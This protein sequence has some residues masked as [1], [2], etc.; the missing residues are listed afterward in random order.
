M[1]EDSDGTETNGPVI[2]VPSS[3]GKRRLRRFDHAQ[4]TKN[5][6]LVRFKRYLFRQDANGLEAAM[7]A[8]DRLNCWSDALRQLRLNRPAEKHGQILVSFWIQ[9]G[10]SS[11]PMGLRDDLPDLIDTMRRFLKPYQGPP[12][13]LYRGELEAR[14][15]NGIFGIAWTTNL[16]TAEMFA[17]RRVPLQEGPGIV[18]KIEATADVIVADLKRHSAHATNI[19]EEE[20]L[21][22]PRLI[23]NMISVV[24]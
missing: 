8:L 19:G 12:V 5:E 20:Y 21:V 3:T 16:T 23:R 13:T 14:Y 1:L 17:R 4:W 24:D 15:T 22:D 2:E 7:R 11:I 9:H 10:L 6:A 18:L